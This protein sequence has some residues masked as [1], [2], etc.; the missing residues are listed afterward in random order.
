MLKETC[1]NPLQFTLETFCCIST[2]VIPSDDA[3][4]GMCDAKEKRDSAYQ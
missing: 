4:A 2:G 3:I 1:K